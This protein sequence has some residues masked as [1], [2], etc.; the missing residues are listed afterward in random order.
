MWVIAK[1]RHCQQLGPRFT[2]ADGTDMAELQVL[3]CK[4]TSPTK[5]EAE[6]EAAAGRV[7]ATQTFKQAKLNLAAVAAR[8]GVA[9]WPGPA[10]RWPLAR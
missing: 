1:C 5:V 2:G 6:T 8:F 4:R 3:S 7:P 10:W 9:G